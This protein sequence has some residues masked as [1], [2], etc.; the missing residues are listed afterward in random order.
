M[1]NTVNKLKNDVMEY[2]DYLCNLYMYE[3]NEKKLQYI[4]KLIEKYIEHFGLEKIVFTGND[5]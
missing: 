3:S 2:Y 5:Y 4:E 1:H